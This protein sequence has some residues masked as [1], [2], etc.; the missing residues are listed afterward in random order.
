MRQRHTHLLK[1]LI[2]FKHFQ[3]FL[4][5]LFINFGIILVSVGTLW[6]AEG[7][8]NPHGKRD[9]FIPLVTL[10]S[11]SPG[12]VAGIDSEKD[13]IIEGVVYDP[14]KGS[15]VIVNG[16]VMKEGDEV[17]GVRVMKIKP[18]GALISVNGA[19]A[20]KQIFQEDQ[21]KGL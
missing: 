7:E 11:K 9:P 18:D 20:F 15:V 3:I 1:N 2:A 16:T 10:S 21:N 8:Y 5:I 17:A 4:W 12:G 13:V 14:R 19:E 6:A